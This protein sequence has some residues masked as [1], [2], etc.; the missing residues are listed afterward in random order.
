LRGIYPALVTPL[1]RGAIDRAGCHRLVDHVVD[2]GVAGVL[3]L[4]S[5]GEGAVLTARMRRV[6]VDT[7]AAALGGRRP[8]VVGIITSSVDSAIDDARHAARAGAAAVLVAPPHYGPVDGE[9][10]LSFYRAVAAASELPVV[11]YN[12]PA[13]TRVPIPPA[14]AETLALEG[15]IAGIKDSSRDFDYFQEILTRLGGLPGFCALTGTDS[16]LVPAQ[17]SGA[18]GAITIGANLVPA[19]CVAA[20]TAASEGRWADAMELQRRLVRL[21]S[22]VRRGVFPAGMKAALDLRGLCGAELALPGRALDADQRRQLEAQLVDLE[23]LPGTARP[24]AG[25]DDRP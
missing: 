18:H 22:A 15:A 9:A 20:W 7:V 10:V 21:S 19:W 12:I 3:V 5:S 24:A 2:G 13:F 17:V 6:V 16:L 1:R 11:A 25:T 14:V 23:V 4:G 8:F